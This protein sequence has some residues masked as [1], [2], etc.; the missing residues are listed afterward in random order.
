VLVSIN[1]LT[2]KSEYNGE[3]NEYIESLNRL[4]ECLANFSDTVVT[5]D[6]GTP[7]FVKGDADALD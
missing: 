3:T 4:N 6:D 1:G 5:M 7:V 2:A